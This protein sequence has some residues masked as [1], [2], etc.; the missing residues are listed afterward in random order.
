MINNSLIFKIYCKNIMDMTFFI[1][2][3]AYQFQQL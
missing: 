3:I 2:I 1:L